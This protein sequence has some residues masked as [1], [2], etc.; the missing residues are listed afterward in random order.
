MIWGARGA[1]VRV[2]LPPAGTVI[3]P[4]L[5]AFDWVSWTLLAL[6]QPGGVLSAAM[7]TVKAVTKIGTLFG[8]VS[9]SRIAVATPG[10]RSPTLPVILKAAPPT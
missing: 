5:D 4:A 1:L 6:M 2:T 7:L 10:V 3:G 8:L 9:V